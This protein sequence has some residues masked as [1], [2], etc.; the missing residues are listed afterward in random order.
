MSTANQMQAFQSRLTERLTRFAMEIY[1]EV[2]HIVKTYQEENECLRSLLKNVIT[3]R[4]NIAVMD[5]N[6]LGRPAT[7]V[8]EE[9]PELDI[10]LETGAE[11]C[12]KRPKMEHT[13]PLTNVTEEKETHVLQPF[14][15]TTKEEQTEILLSSAVEESEPL[16]RA[17]MVEQTVVSE[18]SAIKGSLPLPDT[19]IQHQKEV[20]ELLANES[21]QQQIE[22]NQSLA[23]EQESGTDNGVT[24]DYPESHPKE[25]HTTARQAMAFR[26]VYSAMDF[27]QPST[28]EEMANQDLLLQERPRVSPKKTPECCLQ[29][30][31]LHFPRK[32]PYKCSSVPIS[33]P[34]FFLA[35]LAKCYKDCPEQKPLIARITDDVESVDTA[36]S[37]VPRGYP[38]SRQHL[39]PSR[40][41]FTYHINAPK[42]P[43]L[44]LT[45]HSPEINWEMSDDLKQFIRKSKQ[46]KKRMQEMHLSIHPDQTCTFK[47][48][49][50]YPQKLIFKVVNKV[51]CI[52]A[53]EEEEMM[54]Q[55]LHL[56]CRN[57]CVNWTPCNLVLD[58]N[59]PWLGARPH[60]LVYDPIDDPNF[61][62]VYVSCSSLQS[63]I[64]CPFLRFEKGEAFLKNT[65]EHYIHIQG[66]MLVTGTSWCDLLLFAKEDMLVQRI[67]RD[68]CTIEKM[69]GTLNEYYFYQ[70]LPSIST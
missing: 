56:Y 50:S 35:K 29:K 8:R 55:A 24:L 45:H 39:V 53:Q 65:D 25:P 10:P 58:A 15:S 60:G 5:H 38:I 28:S 64:D 68:R 16:A 66:E 7:A 21:N 62:L 67:Y 69:K 18:P 46:T 33:P 63:F 12:A 47:P 59:S 30:T 70:Y 43:Q 51:S 23:L 4:G 40:V 1:Q 17:S 52:S 54:R 37:H 31:I 61:G 9:P 41:D 49:P 2:A 3:T 26:D 32:S 57:V 48:E 42:W 44:P 11:P 27:S 22:Y 34:D 6:R 19:P 13:K 36:F 14:A 20:S